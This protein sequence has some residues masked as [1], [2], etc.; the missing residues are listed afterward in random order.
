MHEA[1]IH[2][3]IPA[4]SQV[5]TDLETGDDGGGV[6]GDGPGVHDADWVVIGH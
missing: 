1:G 4:S 2:I 6:K 3:A 5:Q